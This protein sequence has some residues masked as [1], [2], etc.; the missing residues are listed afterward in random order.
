MRDEK[1]I[2]VKVQ[3]DEQWFFWVLTLIF[4]NVSGVIV[5]KVTGHIDWS[6]WW[7]FSPIWAPAAFLLILVLLRWRRRKEDLTVAL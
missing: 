1:P 7:V 3:S 6:W 2:K 4:V 5:G